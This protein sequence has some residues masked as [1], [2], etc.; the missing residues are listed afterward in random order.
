MA[1]TQI[2]L[3]STIVGT[4]IA[5]ILWWRTK[6][7]KYFYSAALSSFIWS[8]PTFLIEWYGVCVLGIWYNPTSSAVPEVPWIF[9]GWSFVLGIGLLYLYRT[10]YNN[11]IV[12]LCFIIATAGTEA[13]FIATSILS[14]KWAHGGGW[15]PYWGFLHVFVLKCLLVAI[16][17]LLKRF[18][19]FNRI[20]LGESKK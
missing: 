8:W 6:N 16:D 15:N 3:F 5:L 11:K 10:V 13:F 20:G 7:K 9:L 17:M 1:L 14:G 12:L 18:N 4:I 2:W 19:V